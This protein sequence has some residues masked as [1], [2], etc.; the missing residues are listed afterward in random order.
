MR[1]SRGAR[2]QAVVAETLLAATHVSILELTTV[3]SRGAEVHARSSAMVTKD[4]ARGRWPAHTPPPSDCGSP[5]ATG[6][7]STLVSASVSQRRRTACSGVCAGSPGQLPSLAEFD[8]GVESLI[9]RYGPP[10][11]PARR[12]P[13]HSERPLPLTSPHDQ[14]LPPGVH[15]SQKKY[16]DEEGDFIIYMWT[17]KGL[18]WEEVGEAF[19][20]RFGG[21]LRS[22]QGLQGWYYRANRRIPVWD[23][24]GWLVF[25]NEDDPDPQTHRIKRREREALPGLCDRYP[26]RAVGYVWVDRADAAQAGDW[27]KWRAS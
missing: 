19:R 15:T 20:R 23:E 6:E 11:R 10:P 1:A 7:T 27:G 4:A 5:A 2:R 18:R 3:E 14:P 17:D 21:P 24:D 25:E 9:Q 16:T 13:M 22:V 8:R 12:L 26:E